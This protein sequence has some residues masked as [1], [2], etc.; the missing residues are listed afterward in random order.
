MRSPMA[1]GPMPAKDSSSGMQQ[2]RPWS[3][4]PVARPMPRKRVAAEEKQEETAGE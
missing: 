3:R 4:A 1:I 2:N